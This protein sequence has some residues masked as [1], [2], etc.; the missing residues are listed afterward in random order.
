MP[1]KP[2][3]IKPA[4][5]QAPEENR[6]NKKMNHDIV[7]LFS[8]CSPV[9]NIFLTPFREDLPRISG[10]SRMGNGLFLSVKSVKSVVEAFLVAALPLCKNE[11]HAR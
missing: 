3:L 8:L 5:P 11:M 7:S 1:E 9:Q 4:K 6:G 2:C 10:I